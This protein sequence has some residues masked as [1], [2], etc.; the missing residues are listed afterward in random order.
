MRIFYIITCIVLWIL[1]IIQIVQIIR[2]RKLLK[3]QFKELEELN[4][5]YE[6]CET[7][8]SEML[9]E[10][11]EYQDAKERLLA[12]MLPD[13]EETTDD[14]TPPQEGEGP[15]FLYSHKNNEITIHAARCDLEWLATEIGY[16]THRLYCGLYFKEPESAEVFREFVTMVIAGDDSLT[17]DISTANV[18]NIIIIPME[19]EETADEE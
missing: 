7:I 5:L 6:R 1:I 4:D 14:D 8:H 9:K 19:V 12:T 13:L 17:W 10:K 18:G 16:V 3:R 15:E 2:S 11:Q